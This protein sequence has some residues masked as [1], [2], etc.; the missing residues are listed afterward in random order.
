MKL[1]AAKISW[2]PRPARL[3]ALCLL[4]CLVLPWCSHGQG[5]FP[6]ADPFASFSTN[7][8]V[9]ASSTCGSN[10]LVTYRQQPRGDFSC[11]AA[12]SAARCQSECSYGSA[13]PVYTDVLAGPGSSLHGVVANTSNASR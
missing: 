6:A 13:A 9:Q 2:N 1:T 4:V 11:S 3:L 12:S 10:G 7:T 5:L 8:P